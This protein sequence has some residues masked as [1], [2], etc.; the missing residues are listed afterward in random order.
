V[1]GSESPTFSS[2]RAS[3]LATRF[4]DLSWAERR[5]FISR[6]QQQAIEGAMKRILRCERLLPVAQYNLLLA[7]KSNVVSLGL[8]M[9]VLRHDILSLFN[10]KPMLADP[11]RLPPSL[12]PTALQKTISHH[13]WIDLIP[14][15][16]IR[17]ALLRR[18]GEVDE[19]ELCRDM[20]G[21]CGEVGQ[22]GVLIWG[23]A[24]DPSSYEVSEALILKYPWLFAGCAYEALLATNYWRRKRGEKRLALLVA[25]PNEAHRP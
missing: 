3:L 8:T 2:P 19:D 23:D 6:M 17:D 4:C 14:Q 25:T 13:P 22:A 20:F 15:P 16:S 9:E 1:R 10:S 5:F 7:T 18:L 12:R 11:A 24:A 21:S